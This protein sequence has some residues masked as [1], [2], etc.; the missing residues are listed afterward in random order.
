[1]ENID[2]PTFNE[3]NDI[4]QRGYRYIAGIDE[5]GRGPL[6][7]PV[8]AA[9]VI[10]RG[11]FKADWKSLVNDSKQVTPSSREKLFPI[12]MK[13]QLV[14]VSACLM[15]KLLTAKELPKPPAWQ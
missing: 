4:W 3:E 6:A 10:L 14:L 1:M 12:S 11:D 13:W 15:H 7:G 8:V 9:A 5:A 2:R